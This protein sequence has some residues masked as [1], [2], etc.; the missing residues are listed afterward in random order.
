MTT[1]LD[2]TEKMEK[3]RRPTASSKTSMQRYYGK[4][5]LANLQTNAVYIITN[6]DISLF[7]PSPSY[8]LQGLPPSL[9]LV[10][11]EFYWE[12]FCGLSQ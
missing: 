1:L 12:Q 6:R 10:C 3:R 7:T 11:I 4:Q 2:K 8:R 9:H 5:K